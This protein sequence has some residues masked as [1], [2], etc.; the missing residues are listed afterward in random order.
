MFPL[1]CSYCMYVYRFVEEEICLLLLVEIVFFN[2]EF[3]IL[4][5]TRLL[6]GT[7]N[8]HYSAARYRLLLYRLCATV[9]L[10]LVHCGE[11]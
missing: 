1:K 4:Q 6:A 7:K 11:K 10:V 9:L 8:V 2:I 5:S 3:L